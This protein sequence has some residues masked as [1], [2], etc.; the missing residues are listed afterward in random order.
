LRLVSIEKKSGTVINIRWMPNHLKTI[1]LWGAW[2]TKDLC[3]RSV[4][5]P[6]SAVTNV[7]T[8]VA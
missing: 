2:K 1:A 7:D 6:E 3:F 4:P 8:L 5:H